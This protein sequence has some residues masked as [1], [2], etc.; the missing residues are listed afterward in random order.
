MTL[1]ELTTRLQTLCHDG[2]ALSEIGFIASNEGLI[3]PKELIL[4]IKSEVNKNGYVEVKL[5]EE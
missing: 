1:Q 5:Q 3:H 4:C 2:W